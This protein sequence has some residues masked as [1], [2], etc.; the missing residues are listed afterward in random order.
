MRKDSVVRAIWWT[1]H[2][3]DTV[4]RIQLSVGTPIA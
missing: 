2:L 3:A 4:T 1:D